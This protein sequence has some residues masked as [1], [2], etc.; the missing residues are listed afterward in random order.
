MADDVLEQWNLNSLT[1]EEIESWKWLIAMRQK[2]HE[3]NENDQIKI[4]KFVWHKKPNEAGWGPKL[5]AE[6]SGSDRSEFLYITKPMD[7]ITISKIN[8]VGNKFN[9]FQPVQQK[10]THDVGV[11]EEQNENFSFFRVLSDKGNSR[12]GV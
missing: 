3:F 8:A 11:R 1:D 10:F 4:H 5:V 6:I 12:K 9:L 7:E 2:Y